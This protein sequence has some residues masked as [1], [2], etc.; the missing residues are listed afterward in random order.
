MCIRDSSIGG[1]Q[2]GRQKNSAERV[3][4]SH[5]DS[6]ERQ[7]RPRTRSEFIAVLE[8]EACYLGTH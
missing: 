6:C 3:E 4:V 5:R 7:P 1:E 2:L 8:D